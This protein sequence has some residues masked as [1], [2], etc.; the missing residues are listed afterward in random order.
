MLE[1][2]KTDSLRRWLPAVAACGLLIGG[3]VW[4]ST[5][6]PSPSPADRPPTAATAYPTQLLGIWEG[7]VARFE[8]DTA[9]PAQV[10][11]VAVATLPTEMQALLQAGIA[12]SSEAEL[13]RWIDN[14]T[15]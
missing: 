2:I 4:A 7:R 11:D 5:L 1:Q 15:T 9:T 8:G 10:Y 13:T 3:A 14:L 6:L 12:V